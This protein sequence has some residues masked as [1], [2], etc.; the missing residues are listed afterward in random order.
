MKKAG[1]WRLLSFDLGSRTYKVSY[2]KDMAWG[3]GRLGTCW[4]CKEEI[5]ISDGMNQNA[6]LATLF[7]EVAH[8]LVSA[9]VTLSDG[10]CE[11]KECDRFGEAMAQILRTAKWIRRST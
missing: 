7:H 3:D 1:W 9:G 10:H 11:E 2:V 6:E 5:Q 4:P 8:A